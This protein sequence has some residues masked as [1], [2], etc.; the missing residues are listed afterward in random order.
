M[1]IIHVKMAKGRTVEQKQKFAEAITQTAVQI[2]NVKKEWVTVRPV[3]YP[4]IGKLC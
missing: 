4:L 3:D 1:P 2:L